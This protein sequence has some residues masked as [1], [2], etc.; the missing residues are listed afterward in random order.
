MRTRLLLAGLALAA[1]VA[2]AGQEPASDE[3]TREEAARAGR[4]AAAELGRWALR[5][6]D[7]RALVPAPAP[8]LRYS[9]PGVGRVY[10]DVFLFLDEGRPGAIVS[11][12]KWFAPF[13][14]F[15]AEMHSLAGGGL[16]AARE[17]EE[18]W[19]P[20][21]AGVEWNDVPDAP[22]PS[23]RPAGRLAQMR[24]IAGDFAARLVDVRV[25]LDGEE[26][27]LRLLS[28]PLYRDEARA[29]RDEAIFA[30]VLGTDPEVFLLLEAAPVAGALRWRYAL[31][32]MNRDRIRVRY[33]GREVWAAEPVDPRTD[34]GAIYWSV[35]LPQGDGS[36]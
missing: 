36:G 19:R 7:G 4:M 16:V 35:E 22:A 28:R 24:T 31:A 26:Q 25:N 13:R 29:G 3:L 12:Y 10:G 20:G 27:A 30:F 11:I 34:S 2:P 9:N 6:G 32:R 14:G 33:R 18:I 8:I 17:G 21:R 23:A 1:S 5:T 15:E